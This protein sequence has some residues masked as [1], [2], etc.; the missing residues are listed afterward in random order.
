MEMMP[1]YVR[2]MQRKIQVDYVIEIFLDT[3]DMECYRIGISNLGFLIS[4]D[5]AS[6]LNNM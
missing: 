4:K 5:V 1:G 6:K 2:L 3:N